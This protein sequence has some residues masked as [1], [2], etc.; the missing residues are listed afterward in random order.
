MIKLN[1]W[2]VW[3]ACVKYEDTSEIKKRPVLIF[4]PKEMFTVVMKMTGSPPRNCYEYVLN[5]WQETGLAKVTTVRVGKLIKLTDDMFVHRIGQL[6]YA[7]ATEIQDVLKLL[8]R[9]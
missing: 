7:D 2:D 9:K 3:L 1:K 8:R 5:N 6:S 4:D